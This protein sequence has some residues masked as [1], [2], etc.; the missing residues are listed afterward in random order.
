MKSRKKR[1]DLDWAKLFAFNQV[2]SAQAGHKTNQA[3]ALIG[4]KIGGKTLGIKRE[5]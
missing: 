4:A 5:I 3:Q 2:K 1:I